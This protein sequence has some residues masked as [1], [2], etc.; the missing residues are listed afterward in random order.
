MEMRICTLVGYNQIADCSKTFNWVRNKH[1]S[2]ICRTEISPLYEY[3]GSNM[4]SGN[5]EEWCKIKKLIARHL[6]KH[7]AKWKV[8]LEVLFLGKHGAKWKVFLKVFREAWCKMKTLIPQSKRPPEPLLFLT[9]TVRYCIH[10]STVE[11]RIIHEFFHLIPRYYTY[12][13]ITVPPFLSLS[14]SSST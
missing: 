8:F 4:F 13:M 6:E 5:K 11:I 1:T 7:G 10:I 14:M 3:G 9:I 12:N 2:I